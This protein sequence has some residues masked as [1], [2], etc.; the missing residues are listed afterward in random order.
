MVPKS[1]MNNET[2]TVY[3]KFGYSS[4]VRTHLNNS[5]INRSNNVVDS[6][7]VPWTTFRRIPN[8]LSSFKNGI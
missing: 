8:N 5:L 7:M 3:S 2:M 1:E 4:T 6:L